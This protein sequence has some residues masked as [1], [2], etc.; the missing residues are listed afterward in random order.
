MRGFLAAL[1]VMTLIPVGKYVNITPADLRGAKFFF[2]LTGLVLGGAAAGWAWVM[3]RYNLPNL[4][5]A[6][7]LVLLPE[8]TPPHPTSKSA[9]QH[10]QNPDLYSKKIAPNPSGLA[11]LLNSIYN[12]PAHRPEICK[13]FRNGAIFTRSIYSNRR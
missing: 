2:P 12:A 8:K 11:Y 1:S 9:A 6:V 10:P 4:L 13:Y 3:L 5:G 7:I